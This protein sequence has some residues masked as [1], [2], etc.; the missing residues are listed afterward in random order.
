MKKTS[1]TAI[2][3]TLAIISC[4]W[5]A[6]AKPIT[7]KDPSGK[8]TYELDTQDRTVVHSLKNKAKVIFTPSALGQKVDGKNT[9]SETDNLK[10]A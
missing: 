2:V 10:P 9:A 4:A 5:V 1:I 6:K 3:S 8:L 7:L